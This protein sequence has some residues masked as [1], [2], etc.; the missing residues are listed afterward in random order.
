MRTEL[1]PV[2]K[3]I[4]SLIHPDLH[5]EDTEIFKNAFTTLENFYNSDQISG[6]S[7]LKT[8]VIPNIIT[9]IEGKLTIKSEDGEINPFTL[10]SD[11]DKNSSD[12]YSSL[13]ST[14]K[15][16]SQESELD[17]QTIV[18][19]ILTV[20]QPHSVPDNLKT[21]EDLYLETLRLDAKKRSRESNCPN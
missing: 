2:W 7:A 9:T 20:L 16:I 17:K 4:A 13:V 3:Y 12:Y 21:N 10:L 15:E 11:L 6:V 18:T 8:K 19:S 5:T 14:L 1:K